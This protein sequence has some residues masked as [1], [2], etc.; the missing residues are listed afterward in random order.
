MDILVATPGRL[1]DHTKRRTVDLSEFDVIVLGEAD[2]MLDMGFKDEMDRVM[3]QVPKERT[4]LLLSATLDQEIMRAASRYMGKPEIIEIGEK[5]KPPEIREE[6]VE[7]TRME[8]FGKLKEVLQEHPDSKVII[9]T[10]TKIFANKL[11]D[12]LRKRRMKADSLQGDMSQAARERVLKKFK[13]GEIKILVATDVAAR[14]LHIDDVG[15]IINYDKAGDE[16]THLH[17]VG[18]TGRM[19]AE[20]KAI[21]FTERKETL[22]ERYSEDHPDFAWMKGGM[23]MDSL[24]KTYQRRGPPRGDRGPRKGDS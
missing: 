16:D 24:R 17:R 15:L 6:M 14:G 12:R 2:R 8:K 7:A 13:D 23:D 10:S 19:G 22:D 18:R 9:F 4:V 21:T 3:Q 20:G 1:L 11:A 5:E